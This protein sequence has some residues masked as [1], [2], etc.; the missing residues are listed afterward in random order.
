MHDG[1]SAAQKASLTRDETKAAAL[2]QAQDVTKPTVLICG[3][4]GRDERCGV[5]GPLLQSAFR[6]ELQRRSIDADVGL[7]SHIGGHKYAGNVIMYIPPSMVGNELKGAGVWYGR[8]GPE[9][10][11]GVVEE[12]LVR[13]R[14]ITELL[15]GGVM[16]DGRNIGRVIEAQM[17]KDSGEEDDGGLRLKAKARG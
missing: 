4:G 3:H 12:T 10:V 8:V 15:R 11:E 17:K 13:G 14:V 6:R 9:Q 2:P 5:L 7:I 16:H 1:L